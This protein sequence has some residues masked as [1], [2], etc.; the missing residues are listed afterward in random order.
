MW[1]IISKG[2]LWVPLT[3]S[4]SQLG[5]KEQILSFKVI[6]CLWKVNKYSGRYCTKIESFS[7]YFYRIL[8]SY[9]TKIS[10]WTLPTLKYLLMWR[11]VICFSYSIW[12][13][14]KLYPTKGLDL[15]SSLHTFRIEA[16]ALC[17][18][19]TSAGLKL[20]K[21]VVCNEISCLS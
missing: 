2:T 4:W 12:Y 15:T 20:L 8:P 19:N 5:F 16:C 10:I 18:W 9:F 1:P 11:V 14:V 6:P 21:M 3:K 17:S 13:T 7:Y